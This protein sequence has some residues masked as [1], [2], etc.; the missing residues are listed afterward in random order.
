M[1]NAIV[2]TADGTK[3]RRVKTPWRKC[4]MVKVNFFQEMSSHGVVSDKCDIRNKKLFFSNFDTTSYSIIW[5]FN[6]VHTNRYEFRPLFF[7]FR[8]ISGQF[9]G[10]NYPFRPKS[11]SAKLWHRT[12][13]LRTED[14]F[15]NW[16]TTFETVHGPLIKGQQ[17]TVSYY[18]W[19]GNNV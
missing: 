16:R 5:H 13:R 15:Q 6:Q 3:L 18:C 1:Q 7:H 8:L 9:G 2:N 14:N 4:T 12:K 11:G 19:H 10:S 17:Q